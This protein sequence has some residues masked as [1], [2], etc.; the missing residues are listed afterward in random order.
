MENPGENLRTTDGSAHTAIAIDPYRVAAQKALDAFNEPSAIAPSRQEV[1]T[2]VM[3]WKVLNDPKKVVIS[4]YL[5][6]LD[7][8]RQANRQR[9]VGQDD[10]QLKSDLGAILA[11]AKSDRKNSKTSRENLRYKQGQR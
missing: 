10:D 8:V 6:Q 1:I 11:A 4:S 7:R 2:C 5:K 3:P 9:G